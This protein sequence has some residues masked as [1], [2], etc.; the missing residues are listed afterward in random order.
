MANVQVIIS[1]LNRASSEI[2]KVKKDIEGVGDT[3]KVAEGGV[4]GFGSSLS[5][6]IGTAAMVTAGLVA[7]GAA[8]KQVYETAREAAELDYARSKFDNL[9]E[10]IGTT[11]YL[12][13]NDMRKA[14]DGLVSD[15]ELV[16]GAADFM[17]LGLAKT[18][19]EAIRLTTVA[20]AMGMNMNQLVLTLTNQTTMR[21]DALGMSVDGFKEKVKALEAAGY[22][23]QDAF[24]EAFLQQAEEQIE[25]V[26]KVADSSLGSFQKLEAGIKNI[27]DAAKASL[28]DDLGGA[29]DT[30]GGFFSDVGIM[31]Q[32][33]KTVNKLSAEMEAAGLS[34]ED[35][36]AEVDLL[37]G[38]MGVLD[39]DKVD[40]FNAVV[41][42]YA[43][44]V[45]IAKEGTERW[46]AANYENEAGI[47][48][49][50]N[51]VQGMVIAAEEAAAAQQEVTDATNDADKAMRKYSESLLFKIAS[52]GLSSEAAYDLAVS[53]GLV[54]KNTV[55][56]TKQVNVYQD[57]LANGIID[58]TQYNLLIRELGWDIENLPESKTLTIDDN[59][60][61]VMEKLDKIEERKLRALPVKLE[62][63]TSAVDNYRP[64]TR[65][66]TII[67][68]TATQHI[69]QAVGGAVQ[70]GEPYTWQEY[71]YRGE[72]FVPSADGFIMSRADAERALSKA[73]AG[74]VA[75]DKIDADAIGK[76]VTD[77]LM[78][79][80]IS[81]SGNIYN[82]TMPTSSN[83]ADVRTAFELM[84]AW[85]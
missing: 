56:A 25:K 64:P 60:D 41:V 9:A 12:L 69:A 35:F 7:A 26:G 29:I 81:K 49:A 44:K 71:G 78:R 82:L 77:A 19:D 32:A 75:D 36:R 61:D 8:I 11:S 47:L 72:L 31:A 63:D 83:A 76:A 52:E 58:Q 55:A 39:V 16:A 42:K 34:T 37:A 30:I 59:V 18:H 21:F 48:A 46:A 28:L 5:S 43:E 1:A 3:G 20:G 17:A 2:A 22:S 40:E 57:L 74:G 50:E 14:T 70:G 53:M 6:V 33:V 62:L 51:A 67:Y 24:T 38:P 65:T 85:A 10:S 80:G 23:T 54:D 15:A 68:R 73:L 45:D 79:A 27:G 66:G 13:L 4:K 84:E